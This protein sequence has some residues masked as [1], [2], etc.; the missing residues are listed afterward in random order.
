MRPPA[1]RG[2]G[3]RRER[4]QV[5]RGQRVDAALADGVEGAERLDL[6]AAEFQPH[7]PVPV[8]GEQVED[9]TSP[10]ERPGPVDRVGRFPAPGHEPLG[11][12]G[13]I[14]PSP[15]GEPPR[16]RLDFAGIGQRRQQGRDGGDDDPG[17]GGRRPDQ[18]LHDR[19]PFG[20]GGVAARQVVAEVLERRQDGHRQA[21]EQAE[22]VDE[23]VCVGGMRQHDHEQ[24]R[25][26][27]FAPTL[28]GEGG[29]RECGRR[30]PGPADR[31]AMP[32]VEAG[33]HVGKTGVRSE[34]V[35]QAREASG[36]P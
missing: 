2:R 34:R 28:G 3:V 12:F 9:A 30:S 23:E 29:D 15:H 14:E 19:E 32:R 13:R 6:V 8:G 25:R 26:T 22:V 10:G 1:R 18:P 11:E 4:R 24:P 31:A 27:G 35:G 36:R 20:L 7:G 33:D 5:D 21:R 17:M 16:A